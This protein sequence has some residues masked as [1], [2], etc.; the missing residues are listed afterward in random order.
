MLFHKLK[1]VI[2]LLLLLTNMFLLG[3]VL[4]QEVEIDTLEQEARVLALEFLTDRGVTVDEAVVPVSMEL[5][6]QELS[7][8]RE[9]EGD[10]AFQLFGVVDVES[11]GGDIVR[12]YNQSGEIRF[13][14]N[15]E[16]YASFY[17]DDFTGE[18]GEEET[19]AETVLEKLGISGSLARKLVGEDVVLIYRQELN[20][21]A[22]L[23]CEVRLLFVDGDLREILLGKR[24][25]GEFFQ[26]EEEQISISSAL[27]ACY[28]GF[29]ALEVDV[30]VIFQI[31]PC[32]Q[33]WTPLSNSA[34][35]TAGW[36]LS[37][38]QGEF[39]LNTATGNLETWN[40][41]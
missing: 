27:I 3:L 18:M 8:N 4:S 23:G 41:A 22:L 15:G 10:A 30:Q 29:M 14:D 16:F 31:K 38:D 24:L 17:S 25:E 35:L 39:F 20:G 2:L 7:W 36:I 40:V 6:T 26:R 33:V 5:R 37:T 13:H 12:Y 11:L 1:N 34:V 19:L 32:Y 9:G 21:M 28:H